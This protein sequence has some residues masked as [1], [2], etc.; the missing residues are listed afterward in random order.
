MEYSPQHP[1][2]VA[3]CSQPAWRGAGAEIA[4][5]KGTAETKDTPTAA[6]KEVKTEDFIMNEVI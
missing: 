2:A 3:E 4:F 5:L 6:K 1:L